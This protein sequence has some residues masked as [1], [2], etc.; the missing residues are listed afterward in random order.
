MKTTKCQ[1]PARP[2]GAPQIPSPCRAEL[3]VKVSYYDGSTLT[4][5]PKLLCGQ[6]FADTVLLAMERWAKRYGFGIVHLGV[7]NA[8]KARHK[9]GTPI[10]PERWSAHSYGTAI[11]WAGIVDT[12]GQRL[13]ITAMRSGCPAKLA[14]LVSSCREAI[15][16]AGRKVELVDEGA[17]IHVGIWN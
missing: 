15:E 1:Q 11:D 10:L 6:V 2:A 5:T 17:W 7:W 12:N 3:A 14:E 4:P 13:G 16:R 8:R 9:D